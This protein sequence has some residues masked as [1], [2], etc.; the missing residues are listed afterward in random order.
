MLCSLGLPCYQGIFLNTL[1]RGAINTNLLFLVC[2]KKQLQ[3]ASPLII[4]MFGNAISTS[5]NVLLQLETPW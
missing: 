2:L 3:D 1:R 4:A 5:A